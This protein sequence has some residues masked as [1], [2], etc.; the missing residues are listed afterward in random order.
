MR[1]WSAVD[2]QESNQKHIPVFSIFFESVTTLYKSNP[3]WLRVDSTH[4]PSGCAFLTQKHLSWSF[5]LLHWRS[6]ANIDL[7]FCLQVLAQFWAEKIPTER[8]PPF[9]HADLSATNSN[10]VFASKN[11][12]NRLLYLPGQHRRFYPENALL[13]RVT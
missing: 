5:S 13:V 9:L 3:S 11:N 6:R 10:L 8:P 1:H 7:P 4:L 2:W 12:S